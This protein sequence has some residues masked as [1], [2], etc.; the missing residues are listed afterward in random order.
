L[1]QVVYLIPALLFLLKDYLQ[2]RTNEGLKK[3]AESVEI[4]SLKQTEIPPLPFLIRV[5]P[6][7]LLKMKDSGSLDS[8]KIH[9]EK[10][11]IPSTDITFDVW[12][13]VDNTNTL[14]N[15]QQFHSDESKDNTAAA[16]RPVFFFIH[17]GAWVGGNSRALHQIKLVQRL[18]LRGWIIVCC[19]YKKHHWPQHIDD[20]KCIFEWFVSHAT[21]FRADISQIYL[22]GS[23][24]GGHLVSLL[25]IHLWKRYSYLR[26]NRT[27]TN[28]AAP[29]IRILGMVMF[30]PVID[31]AHKTSF[32]AQNPLTIKFLRTYSGQTLYEWFFER[33]VLVDKPEQWSSA[34]VMQILKDNPDCAAQFPPTFVVHGDMDSLVPVEQPHALLDLLRR[35]KGFPEGHLSVQHDQHLPACSSGRND[36]KVG[37]A[38]EAESTSLLNNDIKA[39]S[40]TVPG[41]LPGMHMRPWP[42]NC[43]FPLHAIGS[44]TS[45]NYRREDA[46]I[47]VHGAF[48]TFES[49][50]GREV[51]YTNTM[52][53]SWMHHTAQG[54]ETKTQFTKAS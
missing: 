30:Y 50:G 14:P 49:A 8:A 5:H 47:C 13:S 15:H 34:K 10:F 53:E 28:T 17:G 23:S 6:Y 35:V 2:Y 32:L 1:R 54:Q 3:F 33:M 18:A 41:M 9:V 20:C 52:I 7:F 36:S 16:L 46:F 31:P 22:S 19:N 21:D 48:H 25:W 40:A 27:T 38:K 24:A 45:V 44:T 37:G 42:T 43:P 51:D 26:D 4:T 12:T 11:T 29:R 39:E